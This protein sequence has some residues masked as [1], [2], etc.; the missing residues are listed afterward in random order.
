MTTVLASM[1]ITVDGELWI[2]RESTDT[3]V[4]SNKV[5]LYQ[6]SNYSS[7]CRRS[8]Q[9]TVCLGLL[10]LTFHIKYACFNI[11]HR[12]IFY[13]APTPAQGKDTT[14]L[15]ATSA[16]TLVNSETREP[17]DTSSVQSSMRADTVTQSSMSTDTFTQSSMTTDTVTQSSMRTDT[18]TLL[19]DEYFQPLGLAERSHGADG[20]TLSDHRLSAIGIGSVGIAVLVTIIAI[21]ILLDLPTLEKQARRCKKARM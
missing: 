8:R 13:L 14:V 15:T 6:A 4:S 12:F 9:K 19:P 18:A 11:Y 3:S 16:R 21:L 1:H 17:A 10:S 7:S 5:G 20:Y 2:V